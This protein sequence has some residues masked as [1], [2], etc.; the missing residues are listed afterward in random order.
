MKTALLIIAIVVFCLL[1]AQIAYGDLG[2]AF[3]R[4]VVVK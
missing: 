1:Y 3:T 4:C 2:C